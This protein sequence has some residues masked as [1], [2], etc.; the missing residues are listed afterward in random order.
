[1]I[2]DRLPL[3][4]RLRRVFWPVSIER[5]IADELSAHLELQTRRYIDAGMSESDARAAARARFGDM[6]RVRDE[7]RDIRTDMETDMRRRELWQEVRSDVAF[8]LRTLRRSPLFAAVAIVTIGLAIGANTAIFTALDA[9]LL[10]PLPYRF[11]D[12]VEMIWNSNAQ[13]SLSRTAVAVPEYF[14]LQAQL[15]A[16]DAVAAI[17]SQ[18]SPLTDDA[19]EP[20]RIMAYAVSPNLF[21]LLGA[22][23]AV[24]R[25]FGGDDGKLGAPRV[26]VLSHALWTRR[27]GASPSV[28]GRTINVSGYPRTVVGVMPPTVRFPD[29]PLDFLRERADLWIPSTFESSRGDSR[30]NQ[31]IA[32]V[33]RRSAGVT[34]AQSVAD[35]DAVSARWR[36][37]YADRYAS[38]SS[39]AWRLAA[40]PLRD[41]MVGSA[42]KSLLVLAAAVAFVLLIACVNVT[43]LLLARGAVRQR[44]LS[45][46]LALGAGRARLARQLLT[47]SLVLAGAG[48]ALG[49]LLAWLGVHALVRLDGGALPRIADPGINP[50]VL[51]FSVGITIVTGVLVGI[52]PALQQ[53]ARDLRAS[54][55]ET[56]RGASTGRGGHRLR[57]VLVAGQVAMALV[58]LVASGLLAR[59]FIA[60]EHV[61]PGFTASNAIAV[62]FNLNRVKYDSASK[63]IGFYEQLAANVGGLPGVT[64][65]SG[66]YPVPM[67]G[68]GWSGSF[69]VEGE[70]SG[71]NNPLPHAEYGVAMPGFF[72]VLG[73]P[74]AAGRDF[75]PTDLMSTPQVVIVDEALARLHWPGQSAVGKRVSTNG[76]GQWATVVG[77]VGHVHKAGPQEEGEPQIY[78]PFAQSPQSAL[79]IVARS[80]TQPLALVK[81]IREV[82]RQLD[83]QLPISKVSSLDDL[84]AAAMAKNRFTALLVGV[85]ALTALVLASVGLYGVMAYLVS[86]RTREIG[87]RVALGGQPSAIRS[88]VMREGVWISIAGLVV[89]AAASLVTSRALSELLFGVSPTDP[90]TYA[91]IVGVL[92]VV[93]LIASYGPARRAT[94]VDPLVALRE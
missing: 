94:R 37:A 60:L 82:V 17:T 64:S 54:L 36:V 3:A 55:N 57:V 29:A 31:I 5:E 43:N 39:K 32:V 47:E 50:A 18:P 91:T 89:G 68:D 58:V 11:A 13:S 10:A 78:L 46:R 65:V 45:I 23:P 73:I 48:G 6:D 79:S 63:I 49:L 1:M 61:R 19:G 88:M 14:D 72:H 21:D 75:S 52:A 34:T 74:M 28:I 80:R 92:L 71:P 70:P 86:Q 38:A 93:T 24:G 66:G 35:L 69:E 30:G 7:C 16:H 41:Q 87:I 2:P 25:T 8:A 4:R 53:S 76:P 83:P 26:V 56:S 84:V 22:R 85:F 12:R 33:A 90:A 9:V 51:A 20:E 40:I 77:V 15:R 59:T 62:K 67:S 44:E 27:F 81:P 42:R